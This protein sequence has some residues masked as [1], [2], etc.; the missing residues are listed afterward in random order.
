MFRI[1]SRF[2][3]CAGS[4]ALMLAAAARLNAAPVLMISIDGMKPEYVTQADAHGLKIPYLR[5]MMERGSWAEGVRGVYPT[6]T[7][8]SHTTLVTGL[9]PAEHGV[10]NNLQF[11]PLQRF[12]GAWNWYAS[13]IR[14]PTLWSAA[15]GAGLK[16]ASIG[17]PVTVGER[18]V[19]WLIPEYW[20]EEGGNPL[21]REL[22]AAL[23]RPD[24]LL[25]DLKAA[26]GDYMRGNE[27][28][29]AGDEEK[30]R[31]TLEILRRYRPGFVTV[32]LSSLD[33]E[34]HQHGPFSAEACAT[35][36]TLDGMISRLVEAE[37][38][39][40]PSAKIVI[41]SD[42][43]FAAVQHK[44][45]LAIPFLEAGLVEAKILP[46][47]KPKVKSWTAEPWMAG[48][49][50]AI[51]LKNPQDTAV[52]EKVRVLLKKLAAD[53][54]NGI[55]EVVEGAEIARRGGFAE[56]SFLV[57][58]KPGYATGAG[59]RG[60]LVSEPGDLQ[61]M[62]GFSPDAPEM[63]ASFFVVGKGIAARRDLGVI[64]MRRIA[65]TVA[66]LLGAALPTAKA[67][68]LHVEP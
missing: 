16:T 6:V 15:H 40:D 46:D 18:D 2:L 55:A 27:D 36:E 12:G 9:W 68:P 65:P 44:V 21:D 67:E 49:M 51:V 47:G 42:H 29:V 5:S 14:V 52:E 20:R 31:Y 54:E 30:T 19:D 13:Q 39:N 38:K 1:L 25:D 23:S 22:L 41:V 63:R 8:P 33:E 17:W 26:A 10:E 3:L 50:A 53:P 64:D 48:G 28:S 60:K 58:L 4:L 35:L 24:T 37:L 57:V 45:N 32:H 66:G 62:H 7:Y 59:L 11:D 61:G 34:E 43:G 56:A